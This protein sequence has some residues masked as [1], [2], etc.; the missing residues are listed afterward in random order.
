MSTQTNPN[1]ILKQHAEYLRDKQDVAPLDQYAQEGATQLNTDLRNYVQE[2]DRNRDGVLDKRDATKDNPNPARMNISAAGVEKGIQPTFKA[3]TATFD[4]DGN[5]SL[6]RIEEKR[7]AEFVGQYPLPDTFTV[8]RP[9]LR[10]RIQ[11][12]GVLTT[13]DVVEA[14][15]RALEP[16]ID[17]AR[18]FVGQVAAPL[19]T[20]A[21]SL[22]VKD[23]K[24]R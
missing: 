1:T 20:P 9:E 8:A 23:G 12:G 13:Q 7:L 11:E 5:G 6:N 15:Q 22:P 10:K 3:L 2:N 14:Y 21:D 16:Y 24:S 18:D 4:S 19:P 17:A